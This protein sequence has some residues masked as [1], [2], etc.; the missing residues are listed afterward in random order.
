MKFRKYLLWGAATLAVVA[1][2]VIGLRVGA[3][4]GV[5]QFAQMD[6]S[7]KAAVL[8]SELRMLRQGNGSRLVQGKEIEVD[9]HVAMAIQFQDSGIPWL[10]WPQ[11]TEWDHSRYLKQVAEYRKDYPP[12]VPKI[13][14]PPG[15][16]DPSDFRG[17]SQIV[18][19]STQK[20]LERYGK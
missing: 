19:L 16:P 2:F 13:A 18:E 8:T 12:V 11:N 1:S 17:F 10:F 7:A 20:L 9:G 3:K 5:Q 4:I 6:S 14:P 15:D